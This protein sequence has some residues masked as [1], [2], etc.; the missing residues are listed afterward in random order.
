MKKE[1]KKITINELAIIT[2]NGFDGVDKNFHKI[3]KK[4]DQ[5]D[6]IFDLILKE[7]RTIHLE[8]K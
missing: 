1:E 7:I 3:D 6:K 2:K 5:H 4:F 8:L